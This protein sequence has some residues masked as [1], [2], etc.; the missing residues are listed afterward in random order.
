MKT[1]SFSI[2][3][4]FWKVI[5][6]RFGR[7]IGESKRSYNRGYV[8]TDHLGRVIGKSVRDF[9]GDL[10]HYDWKGRCIGFSKHIGL[11]K[12]AHF[13]SRGIF[14]GRTY[15]LLGIFFIHADIV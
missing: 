15:S 11:S 12:T 1:L 7:K 2:R 3:I 4:P 6:Y 8:H 10:S 5:H 9:V 14:D 13:T